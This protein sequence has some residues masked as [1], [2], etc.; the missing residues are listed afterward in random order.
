MILPGGYIN[1][2]DAMLARVYSP[3]I[4]SNQMARGN[5][6]N[7]NEEQMGSTKSGN[8]NPFGFAAPQDTTND[9]DGSGRVWGGGRF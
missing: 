5:R 3:A 1:V 2:L 7:S 8:A 6:S 9:R 4:A